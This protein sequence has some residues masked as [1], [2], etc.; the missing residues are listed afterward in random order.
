M[1][2]RPFPLLIVAVALIAGIGYLLYPR[3]A[4]A[5]AKNPDPNHSH[6]DFAVFVEGRKIDF[7]KPQY[8]EDDAKAG[9]G[10]T[11]RNYVHLHDNNGSVIHRHKPGLTIGDFFGSIGMPIQGDC[12]TIDTGRSV[13]PD[14]GKKWRLFVNE[15]EIPFSGT[16]IFQDAERILLSYGLADGD[17]AAELAQVTDDACRYSRTCP[18]RGEPPPEDCIADPDI[19]CKALPQ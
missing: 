16:Y 6:A 13:C 1:R 3:A 15:S 12:M 14:N 17:R 11:M 7:G 18:E 19:P 4:H 9:T 10:T 2:I 5:P 8:M